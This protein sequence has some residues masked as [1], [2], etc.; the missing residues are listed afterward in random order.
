[1]ALSLAACGGS[2]TP[3][4]VAPVVADPV[5]PVV[6]VV[7]AAKSLAFTANLD[8]LKGGSGDDS[9]SGVYY[10]DG[11]TGTT[12][13]PGDTVDGGTGTDTLTIS[14]AG[15][16]TTAQSIN[17]VATTGVEKL[18]VSNFD[19][20][21]DDTEDTTID[22]SLMTGLE[23]LTVSASNTTDTIFS[24]VA[25]IVSSEMK[26]GSGDM[27]VTYVT[28]VVAGTADVQSLDLTNLAAGAFTSN[29]IE[30]I[31]I[32]TSLVKSTLTSVV[33]DALKVVN[34]TGN[35]DLTITHAIDF[36]AGTNDDATIDATINAAAF[37][38]KLTVTGE[39]N[40]MSITGGTGNDT[41]NMVGTLTSKDLI[42]GGAGSDT[43][44]MD[45]ATLTTQLAGVSNVETFQFNESAAAAA[46][47]VSKLSAGVTNIIMDLNDANDGDSANI[48][49]TIT[50]LGSQT[51]T[52]RHTTGDVADTNDSDGTQH[53]ITGATDTAADSI[54]IDLDG[55]GIDDQTGTNF[56]IDLLDVA[57]YE[58]INLASTKNATGT[59]TANEV[60]AIT[61]TSAK[62]LIIT[63][64]AD[65]ETVVT[66][67]SLTTVDA[68][69]LAG[70]LVYTAGSEKATYTAATKA[71]TFT[72][73]SNLNNADTI[74]GG[75]GLDTVTATLTGATV[76]TGKL[77]ISGIETITLTTSGDN[78]LNLAG[79]TGATTLSVSAN[80]QTITGADL[81][82]TYQLTGAATL[83]LTAADATGSSDTLK[84]QQKLNGN[85]DNVV[86][87]TGIENLT[88]DLY[89]TG[90]TA[91]TAGFDLDTFDGTSLTITQ[92]AL[93]STNVNFDT[94]GT[95][96]H[97]NMATITASNKGSTTLDAGSASGAVTM[98]V[99]GTGIATLT[100]NAG[101][102]TFN[103]G[104]TGAVIHNVTGG[105][106]TDTTN[107]TAATGWVDPSDI[108][109]ENVNVTFG[110]AVDVTLGNNQPF[111]AATTA[112][113]LLGGNSLSTFNNEGTGGVLAATVKTFNASAFT[114]N[115]E[116]AVADD[117]LDSTIT[118][119][120][121]ALTTDTVKS[122]YTATAADTL[123]ISGVETLELTVD[124]S[125]TSQ[126]VSTID[127]SGAV[128]MTTTSLTMANADDFVINALTS[129]QTVEIVS[130]TNTNG[131]NSVTAALADATG[132]ADSTTF[133]LKGANAGAIDDGLILV[134]ND[135]ETVN[136]YADS[137]ESITLASLA[138]TTA[139]K[140][141][142]LN[143]TGDSALTVTAT[144]ADVTTIDASGMATGGSFVQTGRSATDAS[145][146]TGSA[147][148]DTF[149]MM[150][151][152]DVISGG[153]GT[154][155][156]LDVNFVG[157][158][159]A[160]AVDLSATGDQV[161][162]LNGLANTV[163]QSGFENVD[164]AGY[165]LSGA[166]I[167]GS[168]AANT[169]VGTNQ[170]DQID[171][172]LG[173][174]KITGGD[175]NDVI[176]LTEATSAADTLFYIN[177]AAEGKDT[178][179]GFV[180]GTD[181]IDLQYLGDA[182]GAVTTLSGGTTIADNEIYFFVGNSAGDADSIAAAANSIVTEAG[183]GAGVDDAA[184]TREAYFV[185]A[186][187]NS[188]SV[189]YYLNNGADD[190]DI[191]DAE[192]THIAT[193]DSVLAATDIIA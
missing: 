70:K 135:I 44:T 7:D 161:A 139:T 130:A 12:A 157:A 146:Y 50:N 162:S 67:A 20:N 13:F 39:T 177:R 10:A 6:P 37:T 142:A 64:D 180:S 125:A 104:S 132:S 155:D 171:G 77:N 165:T 159:G 107:L 1:M 101:A 8:N 121:G 62:S 105:A 21:A 124:N 2:S 138:M 42:D 91:N 18:V 106:G 22:T 169:I 137:A 51:V 45:A 75:A 81:A 111:N 116:V 102:D 178:V 85:V 52:L 113:T 5:V 170:V 15:T 100:G 27:T 71:T 127:V 128:G 78:T 154:G 144:H 112:I 140:T 185:I 94:A 117:A 149:I 129:A 190:S 152:S 55:I 172:G 160:I 150:N 65:L 153:A 99:G 38:G 17:A 151:A 186:D 126:V 61:A 24:N 193:I 82:T 189:F 143:V 93:S 47:D 31:N 69:A 3:V 187:N 181:K 66:G 4:A 136:I 80:V 11:G 118:I 122:T 23:S 168:K 46:I 33:S 131:T 57:N 35:Q 175:G 41:I 188:T 166:S 9:F 191:L 183:G 60:E 79:V 86:E 83:K 141:L 163:V 68:S 158:L 36:V 156:T 74:I 115:V 109:T 103:I 108:A 167:T 84:L 119:S 53:T 29:G 182:N 49:G 43:L 26:N 19:A 147:G 96:L 28:T 25:Q 192:L 184:N 114:G 174:D 32:N 95:T 59:V 76:D 97:K 98:T 164:L 133:K 110:A 123:S 145:T 48:A 16:S 90:A 92:N 56:G 148:N 72:M 34:I 120:A 134:T 58:T 179:T 40:D 89:D 63:G 30:T 73:G 173:I 54:T 176:T 87:T 88:I 14:V